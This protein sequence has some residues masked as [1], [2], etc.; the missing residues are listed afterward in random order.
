MDVEMKSSVGEEAVSETVPQ[1]VL[2][3]VSENGSS[4]VSETV[5]ETTVTG[6]SSE[7]ENPTVEEMPSTSTA[8]EE[9]KADDGDEGEQE[10]EEIKFRE[11]VTYDEVSSVVIRLDTLIF[12]LIVFPTVD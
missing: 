1:T 12:M 3:N 10:I 11:G 8:Q 5:P 9:N 6:K 7:V 4:S 2:E